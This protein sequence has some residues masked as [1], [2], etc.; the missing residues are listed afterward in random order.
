MKKYQVEIIA[1]N[2]LQLS[3]KCLSK[4]LKKLTQNFMFHKASLPNLT[5][6]EQ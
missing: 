4:I 5:K 1:E 2:C 3:Q 6:Q